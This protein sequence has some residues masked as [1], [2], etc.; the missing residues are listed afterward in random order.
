MFS[1]NDSVGNEKETKSAFRVAEWGTGTINCRQQGRDNGASVEGN[2][3][4]LLVCVDPALDNVVT[5]ATIESNVVKITGKLGGAA[6]DTVLDSGFVSLVGAEGGIACSRKCLPS[7][8]Y[9]SN[10][11]SNSYTSPT[12]LNCL[13]IVL[14]VAIATNEQLHRDQASL[15]PV[16]V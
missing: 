16:I 14:D 4:F 3:H 13:D 6:V 12:A 1:L 11:V 8:A 2:R 15:G 9:R 10:A 5:I 7:C